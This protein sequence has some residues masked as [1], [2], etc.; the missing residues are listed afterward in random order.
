MTKRITKAGWKQLWG[1]KAIQQAFGRRKK[2]REE[3]REAGE[4]RK[5]E[6]KEKK[7]NS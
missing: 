2:W 5:K 6:K 4:N 1:T 3:K 7:E